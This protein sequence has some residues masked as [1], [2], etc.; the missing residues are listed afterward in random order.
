MN[1]NPANFIKNY[2]LNDKFLSLLYNDGKT[3]KIINICQHKKLS[4]RDKYLIILQ[5]GGREI[6]LKFASEN[7]VKIARDNL[8]LVLDSLIVNCETNSSLEPITSINKKILNVSFN[9][10]TIFSNVINPPAQDINSVEL[11]VN[12]KKE[13]HFSISGLMNIIWE[14]NEYN[15]ETTDELILLYY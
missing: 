6:I 2:S 15:L 12:G 10:Q 13:I 11:F 1:F 5:E 4:I 9:K 7:D 3:F 8:Q 14:N